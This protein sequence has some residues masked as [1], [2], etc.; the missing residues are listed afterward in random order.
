MDVNVDPFS[1]P[2]AMIIHAVNSWNDID[3]TNFQPTINGNGNQMFCGMDSCTITITDG[4]WNCIE[5]DS[6]C[7]I[8][9]DAVPNGLCLNED[10][11]LSS[12]ITPDLSV[13]ATINCIEDTIKMDIMYG[14]Y[15]YNWFGIVFSNSMLGKAL[16]YT[17]GSKIM[18]DGIN[19]LGLYSYDITGT[20][21]LDIVHN[22]DE[23]WEEVQTVLDPDGLRLSYYKNGKYLFLGH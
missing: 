21:P 6:N 20:D 23:N 3:L 13:D 1:M 11:F 9:A 17:T 8:G 2:T 22:P 7:Y 15:R 10:T 16:V 18:S 5:T 19:R 4:I 12:V 14:N